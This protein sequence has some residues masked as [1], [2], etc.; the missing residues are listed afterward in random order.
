MPQTHIPT[1][2]ASLL[3]PGDFPREF[4]VEDSFHLP[5]K[6][7]MG[8]LADCQLFLLWHCVLYVESN[9]ITYVFTCRPCD[10]TLTKRAVSKLSSKD[11]L[12]GSGSCR[13]SKNFGGH[14]TLSKNNYG[15]SSVQLYMLETVG[16]HPSS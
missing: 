5:G 2:K 7:N 13:S 16:P 11:S 4:K 14:S 15:K 12:L 3:S 9:L 10:Y 6:D 1:Y 8:S